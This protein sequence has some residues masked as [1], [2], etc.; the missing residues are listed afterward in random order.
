MKPTGI[1]KN[2]SDIKYLRVISNFKLKRNVSNSIKNPFEYVT[3]QQST[4]VNT[5]KG[6]NNTSSQYFLMTD[7]RTH[8][9]KKNNPNNIS[10]LSNIIHQTP[11]FLEGRMDN[12]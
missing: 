4:A 8:D 7:N 11:N 10:N 5:V 9:R 6:R 2:Q 3:T 1:Q 12:I